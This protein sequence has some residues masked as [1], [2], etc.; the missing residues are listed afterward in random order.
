MNKKILGTIVITAIFTFFVTRYFILPPQD[1]HHD[2]H[3]TNEQLDDHEG[4]SGAE[5][6]L[7]PEVLDE[8]GIVIGTVS[9]GVLEKTIE[10]P[11][12]IQIDPDRLAHITPRFDGV[13]K[14]VFKQIGDQVIKNE[15]LAV[16]ESNESLTA[17]ELR[18]SID[19]IV[20]DMHFTK[21]E[22]AQRPDHFFAV[23]DLSE[24]WVD[25]SVYQKYLPQLKIGQK[26]TI[27]INTNIPKVVG[28]ISYLSPTIDEH[29]RTATARV[30]LK[31]IDG[32][33]RP[34]EFVTGQIV[35][36]QIHSTIVVPKTALET[37]NG[38]PVVFV[39]DE[40]GFEP[41]VVT[42]GKEN[43]I[44]VEI[45]SGLELEQEYVTEGGFVLKAQMAK[46][47]FSGGHSH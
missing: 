47:S 3:G 40:H 24:V 36:D 4:E 6:V 30:I 14:E 17:Y 28:T 25:L 45:L 23:A 41:Q 35:V 12:E 37:V 29:T 27:L 2:E 16:I 1:D 34:G 39:K 46:S 8:F 31:N 20:I 32:K 44:N 5:L 10:L 11:G 43:H 18:S 33:F 15:L 9:E 21:G 26:A 38:L 22:T 7:T 13:V 42:I 19:G